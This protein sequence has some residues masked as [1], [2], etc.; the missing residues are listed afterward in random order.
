MI[1]HIV[2]L[3]SSKGYTVFDAH[4]PDNRT[5]AFVKETDNKL[6]LILLSIYNADSSKEYYIKAKQS[7]EY[8]AVTGFKK[9]VESIMIIVNKDGMFDDRLV[10]IA[11]DISGVWLLAGDTGRIY[12]YENQPDDFDSGIKEYIEN[13]LYSLHEDSKRKNFYLTPVNMCLVAI[14]ILVFVF[15]I[16]YNKSYMAVYDSDIML[17]MGASSY[18]TFL[19]GRYYEVVTSMF[20]HFGITH[21]LNNMLILT[22]VG[23]ELEK[24]IGRLPYFIIYMLSGIAGNIVS[25][26]YYLHVEGEN[27]VSAGASGA[28][29]G[30]IGGLFIYTILFK[31]ENDNITPRR[32]FNLI[33]LTIYYGLTSSGVDNAAHIG[34]LCFGIIG[35]FLLSKILHYGKLETARFMR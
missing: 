12:V 15:V 10:L 29:F 19:A 23:C 4:L 32:L 30:V 1:R 31:D 16:I 28:V 3:L 24:R 11:S 14:N 17:K 33:V 5:G 25:L 2:N 6:Y 26:W 8:L 18:K 27:V 21:L 13:G 22:Y 35:V 34:G 7:A 20:L 9:S